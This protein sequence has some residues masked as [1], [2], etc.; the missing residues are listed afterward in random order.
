MTGL[1][2]TTYKT[3]LLGL[4]FFL[5]FMT[6]RQLSKKK[7]NLLI[8]FSGL[9]LFTLHFVSYNTLIVY[10]FFKDIFPIAAE[11]S[12]KPR[13]EQNTAIYENMGS[14]YNFLFGNGYGKNGTFGLDKTKY[15][16]DVL[17][18]DSSYIYL[19]SNYGILFVIAFV[20]F[21]VYFSVKYIRF[22]HFN[23]IF[24]LLYF[25]SIEFF[26]NNIFLNT[27]TIYILINLL[28]LTF[29]LHRKY[30]N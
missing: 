23:M 28:I 8:L 12:I 22:D 1:Y 5:V 4:F 7:N 3:G 27:P 29:S 30:E 18:L 17:P 19:L 21:L 10:N 2:C 13:I 15:F 16:A 11:R 25:L 26:V 24:F 14:I 6:I 20:L 9:L